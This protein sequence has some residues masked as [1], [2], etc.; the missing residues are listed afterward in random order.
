MPDNKPEKKKEPKTAL[1]RKFLLTIGLAMAKRGIQSDRAMS[2]ELGRHPDFI[3][4]VRNGV[5]SAPPEAWETL[6]TKFP[7][8]ADSPITNV[9]AQGGGQA[10]G[11]NHGTAIGNI[12]KL[13]L[14]DC[15]R[16]LLD[17]L[18]EVE[19]LRH[20]LADRDRLLAS[21]DAVIASKDEII[22]LLR[23]GYNR[24]N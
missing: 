10:I 21:Q 15:R 11:T 4:R 20:Q 19:L 5:Q 24:P 6:Q 18:K 9:M 14:D 23:G 3:N 2:I 13:T 16:D 7:E 12:E 8:V 17:A 1:D 22:S